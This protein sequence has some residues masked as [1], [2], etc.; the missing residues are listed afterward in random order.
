MNLQPSNRTNNHQQENTIKVMGEGVLS[1]QPNQVKITIGVKTEN[2]SVSKAQT[3]NTQ[4][5][6]NIMSA[7]MQMGV[8]QR[9]IQ[10]VVYQI[11][12]QYDYVDGT[13]VFRTYLITHLLQ[14]ELDD[15]SMAGAVIDQAVEN[16]AN[17]VSSVQ[18]SLKDESS[19]QNEALTLAVHNA[20]EKAQAIANSLS[21]PMKSLPIWIK[22]LS[23]NDPVRF[24]QVAVYGASSD[25]SIQPGLIEIRA[26]I[27]ALF[28]FG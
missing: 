12:P 28:E 19:L 7:L 22:E 13:Q 3:E 14:V 26:Q 20:R 23:Y 27:E 2:P 25:T 6:N 24:Y 9:A 10:T 1:A 4:A 16:G 17:F 21:V 11:E 8:P 15:I 18:F 5:I